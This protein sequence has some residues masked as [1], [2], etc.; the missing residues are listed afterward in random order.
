MGTI[1]LGFMQGRLSPKVRN[2][3]QAFPNIKIMEWTIDD[4][5]YNKNPL[6]TEVGRNQINTL[7]KKYGIKINSI[8]CDFLMT[9]TFYKK[10]KINKLNENKFFKFLENC[11]KIKINLIIV[12]LVDKSSI[13]NKSEENNIISFFN[14]YENYLIK[15]KMKIAFESD[16]NF[17][18][19][20]NI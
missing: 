14:N 16:L 20:R 1:K 3:I 19:L 11:K 5:N 2:Q 13:K 6:M 10:K 18:K 15:N 4:Y 7:K 8:T 9:N 12:P 17:N